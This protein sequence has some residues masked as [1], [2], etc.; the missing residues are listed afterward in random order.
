MPWTAVEHPDF[1]NERKSLPPAV[2]DK[3]AEVVVALEKLGPQLGRPLVDTLSSSKHR[4]MK[5]IRVSVDGAW[6]FAFAFDPRREAVILVGGNKEGV[7][8]KRFYRN[9]IRMA[10][11]RFDD[12]LN[13]EE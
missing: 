1:V 13:A 7:S 6:R 3:L 2:A 8:M 10:D 12:W 11:E 9:L 5:E 4:N